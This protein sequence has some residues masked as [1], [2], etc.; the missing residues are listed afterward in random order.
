V[1]KFEKACFSKLPADLLPRLHF[2]LPVFTLKDDVVMGTLTVRENFMFSANLR[3]S[4]KEVSHRR[5]VKKVEETLQELGLTAC[6]DTK[7]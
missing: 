7:V 4:N 3:L 1:Q 5:K 2:L 6:A